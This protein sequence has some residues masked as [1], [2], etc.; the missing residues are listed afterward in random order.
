MP[1]Y[2]KVDAPAYLKTVGKVNSIKTAIEKDS[3]R[4]G[5]IILDYIDTF[6]EALPDFKIKVRL[7]LNAHEL[8]EVVEEAIDRI[9]VLKNDF[10]SFL[11][12]IVLTEYNTS[13]LFQDFFEQLLQ[14][15]EDNDIQLLEDNSLQ[16]YLNDNFRFF[17][18]ELFLSFVTVMIQGGRY[19]IISDIV[20]SSFCIV[21][22]NRYNSAEER[23]FCRFQSFIGTLNRVKH[24][25]QTQIA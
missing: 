14:F 3:K 5:I 9:Q 17:N 23:T 10:I 20:Q 7:G 2:L 8:I 19:D 4:T 12:T 22:K 21:P 1:A 18:Y 24:Q 6:F 25:V 15:Y 13:E 16:S 11:K